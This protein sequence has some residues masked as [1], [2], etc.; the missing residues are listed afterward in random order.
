[1]KSI[2]KD[3]VTVVVLSVCTAAAVAVLFVV[4]YGLMALAGRFILSFEPS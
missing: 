4:T 2:A 3:A 1:M